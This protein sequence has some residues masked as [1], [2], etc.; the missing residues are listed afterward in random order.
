MLTASESHKEPPL[1]KLAIFII[2]VIFGG[3]FAL[4]LTRMFRPSAE[5]I[6]IVGLGVILV[7]VAYGLEYYRKRKSSPNGP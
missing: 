4:I 6:Y 2:R 1:N 5:P 3:V 7:G